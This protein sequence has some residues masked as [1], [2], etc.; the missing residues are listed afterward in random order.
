[1]IK[2]R[3]EIMDR[4]LILRMEEAKVE[5]AECVNE[6]MRRHELNCYLIEPM[7]A[8]LYMQVKSAAQ[9]ELAQARQIEAVRTAQTEQND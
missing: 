4:P 3:K 1:M 7:F 2:R 8:D 5:L 9:N 6:I